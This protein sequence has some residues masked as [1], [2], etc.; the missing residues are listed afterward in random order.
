[1]T[2]LPPAED[3]SQNSADL[4]KPA[5]TYRVI[6]KVANSLVDTVL[7]HFWTTVLLA[8]VLSYLA[9]WTTDFVPGP[10][11]LAT[12][13]ARQNPFSA[14][15]VRPVGIESVKALGEGLEG[16]KARAIQIDVTG[17]LQ[18]MPAGFS[19]VRVQYALGLIRSG[20]GATNAVSVRWALAGPNSD[21]LTCPEVAL[22]YTS[23]R[24]LA[25]Q[26]A[27]QINNSLLASEAARELRCE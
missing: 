24:D 20:R 11:E 12:T 22:L 18:P 14:R 2:G 4:T 8:P 23:D 5:L 9:L 10:R 21:W 13:I 7:S 1:M 3:G 26:I 16:Q 6:S 19:G 17:K 25:R 15:V 27:E